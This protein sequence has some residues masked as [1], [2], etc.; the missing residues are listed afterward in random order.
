MEQLGVIM[1]MLCF[2]SSLS[3]SLS[4]S[5]F[6]PPFPLLFIRRHIHM[7]GN[8]C[9]INTHIIHSISM[10]VYLYMHARVYMHALRNTHTHA[11]THVYTDAHSPRILKH[12]KPNYKRRQGTK[13]N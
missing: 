9:V 13:T 8:E 12:L 6:F 3:L 11:H 2:L 5:L 7:F 1:R 10:C 4:L